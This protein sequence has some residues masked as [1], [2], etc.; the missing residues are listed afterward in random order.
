M[1]H[2]L[3]INEICQNISCFLRED[4]KFGT[5]ASLARTCKDL[6]DPALDELWTH[7]SEISLLL[8]FGD[9]ISTYV[10]PVWQNSD[11]IED[12][13]TAVNVLQFTRHLTA[14]DWVRLLFYSRRIRRIGI[15]N[16]SYEKSSSYHVPPAI[17]FYMRQSY[18][19]NRIQTPVFPKLSA[20]YWPLDDV[21]DN[22]SYIL[23]F[24]FGPRMSSLYI[25]GT[26]DDVA[27]SA[28]VLNN[29]VQRQRILLPLKTVAFQVTDDDFPAFIPGFTCFLSMYSSAR[30]LLQHLI[31]GLPITF[32]DWK[33]LASIPLLE[34]LEIT[35]PETWGQPFTPQPVDYFPHFQYPQQPFPELKN[36]EITSRDPGIS[37]ITMLDEYVNFMFPKLNSIK[38]SLSG[39]LDEPFTI[40]DTVAVIARVCNPHMLQIIHV[41]TSCRDKGHKDCQD[42]TDE[43]ARDNFKNPHHVYFTSESLRPLYQFNALKDIYIL[44]PHYYALD[45]DDLCELVQA[46]PEI[47]H[48]FLG[49]YALPN[50]Q[51]RKSITCKGLL[52]MAQNS[53]NLVR[54]QVIVFDATNV[55]EIMAKI[56]EDEIFDNRITS[57]DVRFSKSYNASTTA[58]FLLRIFP[59]LEFLDCG[60]Y[61]SLGEELVDD[62]LDYYPADE[63]RLEEIQDC[64]GE[65]MEIIKNRRSDEDR[66]WHFLCF[67]G[68][69]C[70]NSS[71]DTHR[72]Y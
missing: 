2:A 12:D 53:N 63:P 11:D 30:M 59:Q 4:L 22:A 28:T 48:L 36:L 56:D 43:G 14:Q 3:Q 18:W 32:V 68:Y 64:W 9:A 40:T 42:T 24:F 47:Q 72:K 60:W 58:E 19:I 71:C 70:G 7:P 16:V 27:R 34:N 67:R 17:L 25:R 38:F 62:T 21:E 37:P 61:H 41:E 46:W 13:E 39:S 29:A 8:C 26:V 33:I 20:I 52:F 65:V 5:L 66:Y 50:P 1:H 31:L 35:A 45:D 6:Q 10:H 23:P 15:G 55:E 49:C 69:D 44:P 54:E 51:T 57:L